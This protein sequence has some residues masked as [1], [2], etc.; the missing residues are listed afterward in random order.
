M[1]TPY[2]E[3]P[4]SPDKGKEGGSCNR[5]ACQEPHSAF[6]YNTPMRAWYCLRCARTINDVARGDKMEPFIN[7]PENYHDLWMIA[8]LAAEEKDTKKS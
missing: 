4:I 8:V 1:F 2:K 3:K 7:I 5:T 6:C